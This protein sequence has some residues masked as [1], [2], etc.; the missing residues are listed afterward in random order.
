MIERILIVGLGS[1]GKRHIRLLQKI[2]PDVEIIVLRHKACQ[3][4][5]VPGVKYCVTN[6]S[7][8]LKHK[9]QA[10]VISNPASFHLD[11]AKQLAKEG[12]HLL[13]EKPISNSTNGVSELIEICRMNKTVLMTGYNLRFSP[14]LLKFRDFLKNKLCGRVFSVRTEVGQYLPSWRPGSDYRQ[15]VSANSALGGGVLLE[16]SHEID[17]MRW[18]FGE[19]KWV[20][21]TQLKQSD[22]DIDVED[23]LHIILG[24]ESDVDEVPIVAT[25]NMDFI[26][27]DRTRSCTVIAEKG[28]LRWNGIEDTI[29]YFEKG[30][31]DWKLLYESKSER[32][33]SFIAELK[34]FLNCI[35]TGGTP[36][37]TGNDAFIV[38]KLIEGIRKSSFTEMKVY[39]DNE[40]DV[41]K[42]SK[43][44]I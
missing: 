5:S 42:T 7:A 1:I 28:T 17:Y 9:P 43:K 12:I 6:I 25:L 26:R 30:T 31:N 34:D 8:A 16:L 41:Y 2:I 15:D 39:I 21:A 37:I 10:A 22:L 38:L 35:A 14:S 13:I 27:H 32:D 19:I 18:L 20:N 24:F 23:T 4:L 11:I 29:Q 33:S 40:A 36:Q 3:N 44:T